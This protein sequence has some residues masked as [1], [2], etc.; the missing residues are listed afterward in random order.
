MGH[1]TMF[2]SEQLFNVLAGVRGGELVDDVQCCLV[3][4]VADVDVHSGLQDHKPQGC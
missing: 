2:T 4:R 1:V 3:V